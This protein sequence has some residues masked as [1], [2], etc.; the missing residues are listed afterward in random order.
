MVRTFSKDDVTGSYHRTIVYHELSLRRFTRRM[1]GH[2]ALKVD[3]A[4]F[5]KYALRLKAQRIRFERVT[6]RLGSTR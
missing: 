4:R 1:N 2:G 6:E 5:S 3:M